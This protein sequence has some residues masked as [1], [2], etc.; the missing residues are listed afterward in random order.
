MGGRAQTPRRELRVRRGRAI[1]DRAAGASS[2][3][4]PLVPA[5]KALIFI[6]PT[7]APPRREAEGLRPP[8]SQIRHNP[9]TSCD[10]QNPHAFLIDHHAKFTQASYI[11][12]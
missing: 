10:R 1:A 7:E 4:T 11:L 3:P 8:Y 12:A 6:T 9:R 2:A 5:R